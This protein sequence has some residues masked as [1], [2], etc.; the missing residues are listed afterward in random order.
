MS[1]PANSSMSPAEKITMLDHLFGPMIIGVFLQTFIVGVV[2]AQTLQYFS[3]ST[4]D[5]IFCRRVRVGS[6]VIIIVGLALCAK[7]ILDIENV[8]CDH[9]FSTSDPVP[10]SPSPLLIARP[11]L[12]KVPHFA[13]QCFLT[14]QV[15]VTSE[16]MVIPTFLGASGSLLSLALFIVY[17]ARRSMDP[18]AVPSLMVAKRWIF[19]SIFSAAVVDVYLSLVIVYFV[20]Q[21]KKPI[22]SYRLDMNMARQMASIAVTTCLPGAIMTCLTA[23]FELN[24][25]KIAVWMFF[26]VPLGSVYALCVLYALNSRDDLAEE[27][28]ARA[29]SGQEGTSGVHSGG[30]GSDPSNPCPVNGFFTRSKDSRAPQSV[31]FAPGGGAGGMRDVELA[32][33]EKGEDEQDQDQDQDQGGFIPKAM[34]KHRKGMRSGVEFEVQVTRTIER[35]DSFDDSTV[36]EVEHQREGGGP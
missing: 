36:K 26:A 14:F 4:P 23:M 27:S 25:T 10:V 2:F 15:W 5:P 6:I 31:S 28:V 20:L 18:N 33:M 13:A 19:P 22:R 24:E 12:G 7:S 21:T 17:V 34:K 32:E 29:W 30:V 9:I 1:T 3:R 11:A 16:K 8:Y 35:F